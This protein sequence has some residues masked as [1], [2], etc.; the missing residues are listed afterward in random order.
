ML[1]SLAE[2]VEPACSRENQEFKTKNYGD[3]GRTRLMES[4]VRELKKKRLIVEIRRSLQ[5]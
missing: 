1:L 3:S 4:S 5:F 2:A